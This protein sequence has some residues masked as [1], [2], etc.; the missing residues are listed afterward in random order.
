MAYSNSN[1]HA[2]AIPDYTRAI[3]LQPDFA[4]AY[5]NRGWACLELGRLD[6]ALR[7]LNKALELNPAHT[8]ALFNRAHLYQ[9]RLEYAAAI[10]DFDSI[11]QVNPSD[12][13]AA[14]QKA[15]AQRQLR[16]N[17]SPSPSLIA[18]KS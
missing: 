15:A 16:D 14:N 1:R 3:D 13:A 9:K 8:T 18:P 12:T 17:P 2:Q 7:D 5:N 10:A 6:E 4:A 11:L